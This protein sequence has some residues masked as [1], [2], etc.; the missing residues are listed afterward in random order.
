MVVIHTAYATMKM[1]G[2]KVMI[3]IKTDQRDALACENVILTHAGRFGEK[4]AQEQAAKV[5]KMQGG[6][7]L[8]K[9]VVPKSP[10]A[11]SP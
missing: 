11:S 8:L 2:P 9:L 3:T 1:P 5:A 7:I 10:I 6:S 4:V